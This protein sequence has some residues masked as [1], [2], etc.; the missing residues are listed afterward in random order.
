MI[1]RL[2][3]L[4]VAAAAL[5]L[6]GCAHP[7][8]IKVGQADHEVQTELG[9]PDG[10]LVSADGS[11]VLVYSD[12]PFGQEVWWM[13]FDSNGRFVKK[14]RA[15]NEDHFKLVVPGQHTEAQVR[16]MFGRCAQEYTFHLID[17]YALMYRFEEAGGMDMAW[18]VQFNQQGIVT[19]TAVTQDPW[20]R[21]VDPIWDL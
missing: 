1:K 14:E 3:W 12:Q 4:T 2:K 5:V 17:E 19:E 7:D 10:K 21:D 13:H 8:F 11:F 16:Q 20:E 6:V 18:W 15:L 9:I